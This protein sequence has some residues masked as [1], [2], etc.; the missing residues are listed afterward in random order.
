MRRRRV[1]RQLGSEADPWRGLALQV[2]SE[3]GWSTVVLLDAAPG[4]L[5]AWWMT[6]L[7]LLLGRT[8]LREPA[9]PDL[10]G[11]SGRAVRRQ[12]P[13]Q[14]A[15]RVAFSEPSGGSARCRTPA[16]SRVTDLVGGERSLLAPVSLG[17]P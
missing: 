1:L 11:E 6:L 3:E 10:P 12:L 15:D 5:R 4:R 2:K 8:Q 13:S 7:W 16:T 17:D 14:D 9:R